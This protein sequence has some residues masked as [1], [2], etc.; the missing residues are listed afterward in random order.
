MTSSVHYVGDYILNVPSSGTTIIFAGMLIG[1]LIS[2]PGWAWVA[3]RLQNNQ[4]MLL[5]T[6]LVM[7]VFSFP[8]TFIKTS[9]GFTLWMALWGLGFGGF[10]TFMGPAMADIVDAI[11]VS[12]K[13]R[14]DGVLMGIRAF[15]MRFSYASQA[16]VFWLVH[17]MTNFSA[18]PT[19]NAA[20]FGISLH[21]A[22]IPSLFFL[23]GALVFFR[24]NTLT[25]QKI[26]EN[27]RTLAT[28]DI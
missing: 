24:M 12:D 19:S 27:K 22:A 18:D 9:M 7:A 10:W 6:A 4:R 14:D 2:I 11:V 15:F 28:L 21:M 5:I 13:R 17:K 1:T 23:L 20:K 16:V 8:M 3:R 25:P 26:E